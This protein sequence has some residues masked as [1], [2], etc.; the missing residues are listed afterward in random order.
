MLLVPRVRVRA[1]ILRQIKFFT[2]MHRHLI[3]IILIKEHTNTPTLCTKSARTDRRQRRSIDDWCT[4]TPTQ[5]TA[6]V[7]G[8]VRICVCVCV[9]MFLRT[10]D[11]ICDWLGTHVPI[12][13]P[14]Y[15]S[16]RLDRAIA[17]PLF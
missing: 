17:Q 7:L 16:V 2:H 13:V 5:I 3:S 4:H 6:S 15:V 12:P 8:V 10:H 14:L 11:N 9:Y 1:L